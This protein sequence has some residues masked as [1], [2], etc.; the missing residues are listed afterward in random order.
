MQYLG[1]EE[2]DD[3]GEEEEEEEEEEEPDEVVLRDLQVE[4]C[5]SGTQVT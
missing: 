1:V 4:D 2:D 3:D 5:P